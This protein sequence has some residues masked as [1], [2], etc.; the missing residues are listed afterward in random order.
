LARA[1]DAL[2]SEPGTPQKIF[3]KS[4]SCHCHGGKGLKD[5]EKIKT[6]YLNLRKTDVRMIKIEKEHLS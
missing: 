5:K 6:F 3:G 4:H 2:H 1:V